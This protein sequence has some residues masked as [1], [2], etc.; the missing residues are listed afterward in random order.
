MMLNR[1]MLR[2]M[3]VILGILT[4][5][6]SVSTNALL[7][8]ETPEYTITV[9]PGESIQAAIDKAP[10]GA[11][12]CLSAGVWEENIKIERSLTLRAQARRR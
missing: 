1:R 3:T 6:L 10:A 7:A 8:Q 5:V 2:T 12:I 11:V 9:Q 4:V